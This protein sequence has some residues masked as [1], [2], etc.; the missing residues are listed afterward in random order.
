MPTKILI[1][2]KDPS[3]LQALSASLQVWGFPVTP[4]DDHARALEMVRTTFFDVVFADTRE[5]DILEF[6]EQVR[7]ASP[8]TMTVA[9]FEGPGARPAPHLLTMLYPPFDGAALKELSENLL[10]ACRTL[11]FFGPGDGGSAYASLSPA[12]EK[13]LLFP[14]EKIDDAS[15]AESEGAGVVILSPAPSRE[16]FAAVSRLQDR[17]PGVPV[18]LLVDLPFEEYLETALLNDLPVGLRKPFDAAC[19]V[20]ETD[21]I[22]QKKKDAA[23]KNI[24]CVEDTEALLQSMIFLL[25]NEGYQVTGT[26]TGSDGVKAAWSRY[27]GAVI[28]D[29]RLPDISGLEVTRSIKQIDPSVPILFCT[30]YADIDVVVKALKEQVV[31]F[32]TKPVDPEQ[33][34]TSLRKAL[35]EK[36]SRRNP[37]AL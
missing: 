7:R 17:A 33:L 24:L 6:F 22:R 21:K 20:H 18:V 28:C 3:A 35:A 15:L 1:I 5:V 14:L 16:L 2:D 9:A 37:P 23:E 11:Y 19:L 13:C 36:K 10:A 30:A 26:R 27:F 29:Y 25:E 31:D 32:L 12:K 4:A 8:L 34:F